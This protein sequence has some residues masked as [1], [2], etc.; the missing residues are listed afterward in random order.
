MIVE[1]FHVLNGHSITQVVF[2]IGGSM[3][4]W[5]GCKNENTMEYEI[6]GLATLIGGGG[7]S[8]QMLGLAVIANFIGANIGILGVIFVLTYF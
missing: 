8:M 1:L 5:L 3:W 4:V 2:Q 6:F 7:A